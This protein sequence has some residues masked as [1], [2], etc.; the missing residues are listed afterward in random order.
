MSPAMP[1]PAFGPEVHTQ[2]RTRLADLTGCVVVDTPTTALLGA[3]PQQRAGDITACFTD[4]S[5]GAIMASV[6]GND[7]ITVLPHLDGAAI[8]AHP[9]AFFGYSDNTHILNYLWKLGVQS[10]HGGATQVHIGAGSGVDPE[11]SRS[12]QAAL[13]GQSITIEAVA[14][15][16]DHGLPWDDPRAL[17][18][19][20][21]RTPPEPWRWAGPRRRVTAVTWGG[22]V[23][24]L[25]DIFVA[26]LNPP[27][28]E[29]DGIALLLE[30]SDEPLTPLDMWYFLRALGERGILSRCVAVVVAR[31][32]ATSFDFHP[33]LEQ[34]QA[35]RAALV[36]TVA[37]A[38]AHYAP[39]AVLCAGPSFGHTRPQWILPYGG[40]IT[41][42]GR[43]RTITAHF[44]GS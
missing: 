40:L 34:Q 12:L 19:D 3:S 18:D 32:P 29:L 38:C 4:A 17:T 5:I 31:P 21:E 24:V 1:G 33:P 26:G 43:E 37:R 11:H 16:E 42:D 28:A 22:C 2:A 9:T 39:Q 8:A 36:D 30:L 35:F 41:V 23:S 15:S 7:T 6:G 44:G 13:S 20:G 27:D 10:Y 25:R 14:S